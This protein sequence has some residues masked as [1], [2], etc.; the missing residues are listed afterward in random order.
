MDW[1]WLPVPTPP[2]TSAPEWISFPIPAHKQP[3]PS[4]LPVV[5][6]FRLGGG[7]SKASRCYQPW[8][9]ASESARLPGQYAMYCLKQDTFAPPSDGAK[10]L[11]HVDIG[12]LHGKLL[13][14]FNS[15]TQLQD[16]GD[17]VRRETGNH[18]LFSMQSRKQ[19]QLLDGDVGELPL[20]KYANDVHGSGDV[21]NA[22]LINGRMFALVRI[23]VLWVQWVYG[24]SQSMWREIVAGDGPTHSRTPPSIAPGRVA[25]PGPHTQVTRASALSRVMGYSA[26]SGYHYSQNPPEWF[27]ESVSARMYCCQHGFVCFEGECDTSLTPICSRKQCE[28]EARTWYQQHL[29]ETCTAE[30]G[31]SS[32]TQ[33]RQSL[34]DR[35]QMA[36][37]RHEQAAAQQAEQLSPE[38]LVRSDAGGSEFGFVRCTYPDDLDSKQALLWCLDTI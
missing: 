14:T 3:L 31:S 5:A 23:R 24:W 7:L 28:V 18:Y 27:D 35:W 21:A 29:R 26:G 8:L 9:L 13:G 12:L 22:A 11:Q 30:A 19:W 33:P 17:C 20:L 15:A 1:S 4:A 25:A 10:G 16:A 37:S 36:S 38:E 2:L 34:S 32:E 6:I